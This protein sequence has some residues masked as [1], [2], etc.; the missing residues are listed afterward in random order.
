MEK[1]TINMDLMTDDQIHEKLSK[2]LRDV[3]EG[4]VQDAEQAFE[5]FRRTMTMKERQQS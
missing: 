1:P 3:K 5:A 4:R 2:G